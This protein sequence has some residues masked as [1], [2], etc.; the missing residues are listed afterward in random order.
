[1][2]FFDVKY[3]KSS[4]FIARY[5][6]PGRTQFPTPEVIIKRLLGDDLTLM[7]WRALRGDKNQITHDNVVSLGLD[8]V[9]HCHGDSWVYDRFAEAAMTRKAL[10]I[11]FG[12]GGNRLQGWDNVDEEIDIRK[13]LPYMSAQTQ[14]ILAEHVVEHVTYYE[15]IEFFKECR[16]VLR[17]G[18]V[19][20]VIVPSVE[21]I[22]K[23]G[24]RDYFQFTTRWQPNA[25]VRGAMYNILYMHGHKTAWTDSLLEATLFF[26]GFERI[27][28]CDPRT[29]M[30]R[31]L[32]DVD[33]HWKAIGERANWIESCVYEAMV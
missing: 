28:R 18:G 19:L 4:D 30:H 25:T 23:R 24:D 26:A 6:W 11:N 29:S 9:T 1:L 16:R 12:C 14:F 5:D 33:G 27:A 2:M 13:P 21:N 22:W 15:A 8:W 3:L 31:E 32:K 10:K 7:P 17:L 20:R